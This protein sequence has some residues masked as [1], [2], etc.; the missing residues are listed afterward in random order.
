MKDLSNENIVHVKH[1]NIEYIQFKKAIFN[2]VSRP[3]EYDKTSGR[4]VKMTFRFT[5][6]FN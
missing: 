4:I 5:G 2:F 3:D 6:N 1:G